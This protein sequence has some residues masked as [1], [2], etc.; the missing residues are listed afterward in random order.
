VRAFSIKRPG[1]R[2]RTTHDY[3]FRAKPDDKIGD[4]D[5][6]ITSRFS[7]GGLCFLF[8]RQGSLNQSLEI[9]RGCSLRLISGSARSAARSEAK[10]S[11]QI[12]VSA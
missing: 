9:W 12:I 10:A 1:S 2:Y 5:G 7:E 11:Q 6:E 8:S 4:T 3:S